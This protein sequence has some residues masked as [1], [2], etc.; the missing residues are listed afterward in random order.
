ML[1]GGRRA[2]VD[3]SSGNCVA[4]LLQLRSE[5]RGREPEAGEPSSDG[6]GFSGIEASLR[7]QKTG[8]G[9][10]EMSTRNAGLLSLALCLLFLIACTGPTTPP[11][12]A[13]PSTPANMPARA[14]QPTRTRLPTLTPMPTH[15]PTV[16]P[17]VPTPYPPFPLEAQVLTSWPPLPSDL[18][19]LRD[20]RLWRWP[21]AGGAPEELGGSEEP[22]LDYRL[23]A[24]GQ[25]VAYLTDRRGNAGSYAPTLVDNSEC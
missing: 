4:A 3:N 12:V 25:R 14:T 18:Y 24:D 7:L 23:A 21:A 13:V 10:N 2:S 5:A 1:D 17:I 8:E 19:F 11:P 6:K 22:V 16:T 20:G 15:P 9:E